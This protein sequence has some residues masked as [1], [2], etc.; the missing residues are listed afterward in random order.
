MEI[1]AASASGTASQTVTCWSADGTALYKHR[2]EPIMHGKW[3]IIGNM[4]C[5]DWKERPNTGCGRQDMNG[6]TVTASANTGPGG[7]SASHR[8]RG[9]SR[10]KP[11]RCMKPA[12]PCAG[13]DA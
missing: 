3:N 7:I 11:T 5:T 1:T 12:G 10:M 4:L 13:R 2:R 9:I 6:D 8:R